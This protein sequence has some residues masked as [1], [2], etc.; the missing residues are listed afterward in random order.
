MMRQSSES[1]AR[2]KVRLQQRN[3]RYTTARRVVL[4]ALQ[5]SDG[6]QS[7]AELAGRLK[8]VIPL[9]SLYRTLTAFE[10]AEILERFHDAA[11]V[12]RYELA[13]WLAGHHHHMT[14]IICGSTEDIPLPEGLETLI[15]GF[16]AAVEGRTGFRVDGHRLDL[17]GVCESC[18]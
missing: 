2:A 1:L 10:G 11:G 12:A 17:E 8:G 5:E 4:E 6:P 18:R 7:P 16:V 15:D 3:M 14:C 9:S 13:E